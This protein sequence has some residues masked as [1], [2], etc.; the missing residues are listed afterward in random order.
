MSISVVI[1]PP[2][3]GGQTFST[4]SQKSFRHDRDAVRTTVI[5]GNVVTVIALWYEQMP[6]RY[7]A[8]CLWLQEKAGASD[9]AL[10][11]SGCLSKPSLSSLSQQD[12]TFGGKF[13]SIMEMG[14]AKA[15]LLFAIVAYKAS[16]VIPHKRLKRSNR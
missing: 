12:K 15:H 10:V 8:A 5:Q 14:D 4:T 1:K 7:K 3:P 16:N 9:C 11:W 6:F 13:T 2:G